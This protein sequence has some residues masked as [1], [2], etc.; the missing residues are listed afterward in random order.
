[1]SHS[2]RMRF[3]LVAVLLALAILLTIDRVYSRPLP[4]D[5]Q[6]ADV[7]AS[8]LGRAKLGAPKHNGPLTII[9]LRIHDTPTGVHTL[10]QALTDGSLAIHE[11]GEGRVNQLEVENRGKTSVFIMAGQILVGA[12]QNRVLKYDL[13]LPPSSGRVTVEAF[14]VQH[15]RW[16]YQG[17]KKEFSH[18]DNVSNPAV[19]QAATV[20]KA[21]STVWTSVDDT[22]QNVGAAAG[23]AE[24]G[25]TSDL[26]DVYEKKEVRARITT[27]ESAFRDLP[28]A[29]PDMQGAVVLL[30]GRIVAVDL[31]G[32]RS[33]FRRLWRPLL[34]SY[35]LEGTRRNK[36]TLDSSSDTAR[37]FL[38]QA[39]SSEIRRLATP[40]SGILVEL[41]GRRVSGDAL[42]AAQTVIHLDLFPGGKAG[43]NVDTH[44]ENSQ[45]NE[46][47]IQRNR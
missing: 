37:A 43:R 9:P 1:M 8:F 12:K 14:C 36:G 31:F 33:I 47:P 25:D 3:S 6:P 13:L 11:I 32:D 24:R 46:P 27:F 4:S 2:S 18:S 35:V 21:Q 30:D 10:A 19:R 42:I 26:N 23:P 7:L 20:S 45:P 40:G 5:G 44:Q 17:D 22:R 28:Q 34:A 41:M 39:M 15:G 38:E 16:S 29:I